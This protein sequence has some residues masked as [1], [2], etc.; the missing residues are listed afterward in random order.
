MQD[1]DIRHRKISVQGKQH[2]PLHQYTDNTKHLTDADFSNE[3]V[4]VA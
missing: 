2:D 1:S 4:P 3:A